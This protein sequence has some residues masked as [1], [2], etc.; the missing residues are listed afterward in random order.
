MTTRSAP[1]VITLEFNL[2]ASEVWKAITQ[3]DQLVQWFFEEIPEFKAE[4]GFHTSFDVETE[5]E[6]FLHQWTIV[7][8]VEGWSIVYDWSYRGLPGKG[9]VTFE[10]SDLGGATLLTLTNTG[11][12][13]FPA[14]KPEFTRESC[15]AGWEYFIKERLT[16]YLKKL[17]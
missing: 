4:V 7:E 1:I 14:D 6:H 13:S 11:L 3:R 9:L 17:T 2:P 16:N 8:V 15:I 12:E 5:N 10:L